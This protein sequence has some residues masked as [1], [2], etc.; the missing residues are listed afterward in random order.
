[1]AELATMRAA[2]EISADELRAAR[3]RLTGQASVIE[4]NRAVEPEEEFYVE[5]PSA[6]NSKKAKAPKAPKKKGNVFFIIGLLV[7]GG[8]FAIMWIGSGQPGGSGSTGSQAVSTR[9]AEQAE[10]ERKGFHCLS[11]WDGSNRAL[12]DTVKNSM[13]EP[14]SFEHIETRITPVNNGQHTIIMEYRGRNGFGG[15]SVETA[16]GTLSNNGCRLTDVASL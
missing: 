7:W 1:M 3:L 4:N 9:A 12:V 8:L 2:G 16:T 6:K 13:R 11:S 14:G 15:M 5:P 10:D